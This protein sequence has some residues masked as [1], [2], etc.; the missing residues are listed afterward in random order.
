MY[1]KRFTNVIYIKWSKDWTIILITHVFVSSQDIAADLAFKRPNKEAL[2]L[3]CTHISIHKTWS[4]LKQQIRGLIGEW[5]GIETINLNENQYLKIWYLIWQF[6][7]RVLN[8]TNT[9]VTKQFF[10]YSINKNRHENKIAETK[11]IHI[12]TC[13]SW[14]E[15]L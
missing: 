9:S 10:K 15:G 11:F 2:S 14:V 4:F 5:S 1:E 8:S 7:L 6:F 13:S 12:H 3:R